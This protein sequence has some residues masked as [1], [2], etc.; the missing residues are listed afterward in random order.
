MPGGRESTRLTAG[1]SK[2]F[3]NH[4]H[5]VA[6]YTKWYKFARVNSAVRMS[7]A[8]A[9]RLETR[10]WDIGDIVKLIEEYEAA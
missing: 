4:V 8:M 2:K 1:H 9:A 7:P 5:M 10:L 6:L 3:G